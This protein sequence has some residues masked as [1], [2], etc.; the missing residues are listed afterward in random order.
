MPVRAD[1]QREPTCC[2]TALRRRAGTADRTPMQGVQFRYAFTFR[3]HPC[4]TTSAVTAGIAAAVRPSLHP[5]GD[6]F[7]NESSSSPARPL[8]KSERRGAAARAEARM[9]RTGRPA[10]RRRR[11]GARS[12]AGGRGGGCRARR[13]NL[14]RECCWHTRARRTE[15]VRAR[16]CGV[17]RV[18]RAC[19]EV[20]RAACSCARLSRALPPPLSLPPPSPSPSPSQSGCG[21][22]GLRWRWV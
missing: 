6:R 2:H 7:E 17:R 22:G 21:V 14:D 11:G 20:R 15:P 3:A 18:E 1:L 9:L 16:M 8:R 13:D 12:G 5:S 10:L 4:S 19:A